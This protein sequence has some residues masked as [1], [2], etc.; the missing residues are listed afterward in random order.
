G[1]EVVKDEL[2]ITKLLN[3]RIDMAPLS[4][5]TT[6]YKASKNGYLDKITYLPKP[7]KSEAYYNTF[8]KKSDYPGLKDIIKNYD[9]I[10]SRMKAEGILQKI[11]DKYNK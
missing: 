1:D 9:A 2:Q 11:R 5:S 3:G 7:M 10:L 8:V 4:T 6:L